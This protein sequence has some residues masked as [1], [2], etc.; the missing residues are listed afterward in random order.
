MD[1]VCL[2]AVFTHVTKGCE[3]KMIWGFIMVMIGGLKMMT[4]TNPHHF[5]T[6]LVPG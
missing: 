1:G 5:I 2:R 6:I 4:K 3:E